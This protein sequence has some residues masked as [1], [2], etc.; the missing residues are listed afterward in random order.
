MCGPNVVGVFC[1]PSDLKLRTRDPRF[2]EQRTPHRLAISGRCQKPPL[3][4]WSSRGHQ[5]GRE[6]RRGAK[7]YDVKTQA[8]L[9]L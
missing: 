3:Q 4:E 9:S 7:V 8:V 1:A 2:E 5:S 6:V